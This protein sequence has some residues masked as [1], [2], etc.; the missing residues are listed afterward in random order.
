M[1]ILTAVRRDP[2]ATG[3]P[4]LSVVAL[5]RDVIT[6][7]GLLPAGSKGTVVAVYSSGDGYEVEFFAPFHAV[8]T[9]D[10]ADLTA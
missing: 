10:G 4:E 7:D 1:T 5:V 2:P 6:D 3:F 8:E 9:L